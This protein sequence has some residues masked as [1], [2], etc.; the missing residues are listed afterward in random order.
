M[1]YSE[2]AFNYSDLEQYPIRLI[3]DINDAMKIKAEKQKEAMEQSKGTN[4]RTFSTFFRR[5][6]AHRQTHFISFDIFFN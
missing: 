2:G 5:A 6:K 4:R 1:L 3:T